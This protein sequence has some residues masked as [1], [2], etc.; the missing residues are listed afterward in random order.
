MNQ[1]DEVVERMARVGY[2]SM[3][4]DGWDEVLPLSVERALW[5]QIASDMLTELRRTWEQE[6]K[7][8]PTHKGEGMKITILCPVRNGT[9]QEVVDYVSYMESLG[10]ELYLPPRD[11]P[12]ED[13]SG[14]EICSRMKAAIDWADRVDI[15]YDKSSQGTHFDLGMAFAFGKKLHLINR[16]DDIDE[17]SYLKVVQV[18]EGS[19]SKY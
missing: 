10:H 4:D 15:F 14:F 8:T 2:E 11:T 18:V 3:Y 1:E 7:L 13:P 19:S 9:P 12:Q 6:K 17:K 16:P 5:L